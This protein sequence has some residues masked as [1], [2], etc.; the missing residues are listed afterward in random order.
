MTVTW[1]VGSDGILDVFVN[2]ALRHN[3]FS[4]ETIE[5]LREALEVARLSNDVRCVLV[6]TAGDKVF[7]SGAD[8]DT[9][10]NGAAELTRLDLFGMFEKLENLEAPVVC[11]VQGLALGG[12]FEF[13][14][15]CDLVVAAQEAQ[16]GLPETALGLAPGIAMIRLYQE[17]GRHLTKELAFTGRRLSATEAASLGL[18]NR[19][20]P[21]DQLLRE[22]RRLCAEVA[23]RAP[24]AIRVT[25][26]A[27]NREWGG[28]D[29]AFAREAMDGVFRTS[30]CKEGV[31]AFKERR[32]PSFKGM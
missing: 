5:G 24:V 21:R 23:E 31:R 11:A 4:A 3:P 32:R 7:M 27:V 15:C 18:V 1:E 2:E 29:W 20:V 13:A 10:L 16:F 25:K 8:L 9:M 30:D 26:R 6:R 22:A 19:V 17:I 12:G 14:V 28:P